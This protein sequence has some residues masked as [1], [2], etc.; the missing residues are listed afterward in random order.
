[1]LLLSGCTLLNPTDGL[2][3]GSRAD[4]SSVDAA[5]PSDAG[6]DVSLPEGGGPDAAAAGRGSLYVIGGA[7][8]ELASTALY[9]DDV[10]RA[11]IRADGTLDPWVRVGAFPERIAFHAAAAVGSKVVVVGGEGANGFV[12]HAHIADAAGGALGPWISGPDFSQARFRLAAAGTSDHAYVIGGA[13]GVGTPRPD[14]Q[15]ASVSGTTLAPWQATTALPD[16]RQHHAAVAVK[17]QIYVVGGKIGTSQTR[18]PTVLGANVASDGTVSSWRGETSLPA[19]IAETCVVETSGALAVIGGLTADRTDEVQTSRI[20]AV[21]TL[22]TWASGRPIPR[23][24][25]LHACASIGGHVYVAG[26]VDASGVVL[27]SV[28]VG[29]VG[30][31]GTVGDWRETQPLPAPR[32]SFAMVA[33]P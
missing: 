25:S 4:A 12:A 17:D 7:S 21:G 31:D 32:Q 8:S 2:T 11:T 33:V 24:R 29:E 10:Y 16:L 9:V 28:V 26:G 6:A 30:T 3:G 15:T 19:A 18:T 20:T 27:T 1:V 5:V 13:Q 23:A 22:G 14:V